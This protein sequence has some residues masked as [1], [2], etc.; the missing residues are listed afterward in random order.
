MAEP[1]LSQ[2]AVCISVCLEHIM[3]THILSMLIEERVG[4]RWVGGEVVLIL[5]N[6]W[7]HVVK[8]KIHLFDTGSREGERERV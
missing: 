7:S 3:L 2:S 6:D 5:S 8:G 4:W 1:V